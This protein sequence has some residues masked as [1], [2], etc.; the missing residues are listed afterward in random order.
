M[1]VPIVGHAGAGKTG[2]MSNEAGR[3]KGDSEW[4]LSHLLTPG[5]V[6]L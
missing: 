1:T 3:V 2:D 6:R 4:F 5:E